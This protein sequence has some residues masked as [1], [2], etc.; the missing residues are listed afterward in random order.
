MTNIVSYQTK[1]KD[2]LEANIHSLSGKDRNTQTITDPADLEIVIEK[3]PQG[4]IVLVSLAQYWRWLLGGV[5]IIGLAIYLAG[6]IRGV[7][8]ILKMIGF[9]VG[10]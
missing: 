10:N 8:S 1:G 2:A 4:W 9:E 5:G 3:N 6:K 7:I